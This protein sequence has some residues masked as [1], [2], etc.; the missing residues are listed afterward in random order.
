[1]VSQRVFEAARSAWI[2]RK[3]AQPNTKR[4]GAS[5]VIE[6]GNFWKSKELVQVRENITNISTLYMHVVYFGDHER[7]S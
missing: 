7:F 6:D 3:L 2:R 1:M 4:H 5:S